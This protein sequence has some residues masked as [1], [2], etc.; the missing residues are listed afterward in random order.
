ML[1]NRHFELTKPSLRAHEPP[2]SARPGRH[3]EAR[4]NLC[5]LSVKVKR[6]L[7][8]SRRRDRYLARTTKVAYLTDIGVTQPSLY[9]SQ[10]SLYASQ[11]SLRA[12]E[13]P[14]SARPGRHCE[15]RSNL[16]VLPV[17]VERSLRTS[18][19]RDRYLEEVIGNLILLI[20]LVYLHL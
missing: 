6:S 19:G 15:A 1:T 13:P 7:R 18:R 8:T 20:I 17:K 5:V 10:L 9:S 2:L 14:L 4:S 11:S 16:S 12:Q 3:C